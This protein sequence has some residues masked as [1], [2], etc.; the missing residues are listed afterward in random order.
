MIA[1]RRWTAALPAVALAATAASTMGRAALVTETYD[2]NLSNFIDI[3]AGPPV[4]SPLT[5]ITG[6]FTIS[7]D[8]TL[9][10]NNDTADIVVRAFSDTQ[11]ASAIGFDNLAS[12][13]PDVPDFL[14][15]GGVLNDAD[16]FAFATDDFSINI[17]FT[18]P[19]DPR[20]ALCGDGYSCGSAAGPTLAAGYGLAG[21]PDDGWLATEGSV[22]LPEPPSAIAL[23]AGISM[24]GFVLRRS[25]GHSQRG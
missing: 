19:A 22:D 23:L 17:K 25:G 8:P 11:V 20:M 7:F 15:I 16:F 18:D 5:L 14:A 2:F 24:L 1:L 13:G 12:T 6:S 9:T 3:G 10:F 21:F 4:A